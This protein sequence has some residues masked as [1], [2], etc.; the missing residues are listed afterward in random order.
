MKK[1]I[2]T[3][4]LGDRFDMK[5]FD[6]HCDIGTS[7]Y[8]RYLLNEKDVFKKYHLDDL[9]KGD[10]KGVCAVCY[11]R[12]TEDWDFMQKL[13]TNCNEEINKFK[14]YCHVVKTKEDIKEDDKI[15]T[16]IAVEGMCGVDSDVEKN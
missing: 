6:M 11:F 16:F 2:N 7:L 3:E 5:I 4:K 8:D 12:G 1:Q 13:I 9:I 14:D 10:V 15:L